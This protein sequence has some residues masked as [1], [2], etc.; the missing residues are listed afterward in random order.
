MGV[1]VPARPE[2]GAGPVRALEQCKCGASRTATKRL[3]LKSFIGSRATRYPDR[4]R[5]FHDDR[6]HSRTRLLVA[7]AL[8]LL[9]YDSYLL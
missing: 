6:S 4:T 2:M 9:F 8:F 3:Y 7:M 5:S 1:T